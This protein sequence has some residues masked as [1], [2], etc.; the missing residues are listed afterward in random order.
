MTTD[1]FEQLR[2]DDAPVRPDPGFVARLRAR[3]VAALESGATDLPTIPLPDRNP[4]MTETTTTAPAATATMT[5]YICVSPAADALAWYRDVLDA[6]E[7][8]RYTGDDGRIGH[9]EITIAG[10]DV[11][12]SDEYPDLGVVSPTTLGGTPTTLHLVVPDADATYERVVANGG[13]AAG[14]PKDEPYGYRGFSMVDPFGHR[15][16]IQTEIANPSLEEIQEAVE[17]YTITAPPAEPAARQ[18]VELG[19]VTIGFPDTAAAGRFYGELFGWATE[20]GNAGEGYAHVSNTK[21]PLGLTPGSADEAPVL[22]FRVDD[23]A[24]YAARVGELG[25]EVVS[26]TVYESGPNAVCRDDQGRE[27]QLWQPAP[28]Y[29]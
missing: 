18:V 28:G 4:T 9:A 11:M 24:G 20:P 23:L 27:F 16:M 26:E 19:Y 7:T 1:P 8:V 15:W 2:I 6:V 25:G 13:R 22:Y 5:P 17:G 21:L 29:E 14:A 12:L 10:A 3:L